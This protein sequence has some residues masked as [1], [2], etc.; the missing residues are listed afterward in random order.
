MPRYG[1]RAVNL[2]GLDRRILASLQEGLPPVARPYQAIAHEAGCKEA[3]VFTRIERLI[4][5]G[6]IRRLGLVVRHRKLG[7]CS[8]AMVVW[9]IEDKQ[10]EPIAERLAARDEIALCYRRPRRPPQWPFNLYC[11]IYGRSREEVLERLNRVA[12]EEELTQWA[13]EPLFTVHCYKQTGARYV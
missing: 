1:V 4:R 2:D 8:N 9:D 13:H 3:E 6:V 5:A 10:V 7:F 11:M 12:E